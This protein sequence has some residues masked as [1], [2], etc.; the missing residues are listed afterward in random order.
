MGYKMKGPSLYKHLTTKPRLSEGLHVNHDA[1]TNVSDGRAGSSAFQMQ[2]DLDKDGKM[3]GYE[4]A[5]QTAIEKN[6]KKGPAKMYGKKS[7]TKMKDG[8][9]TKEDLLKEGFTPADADKMMKDGATTG[10]PKAKAKKKDK[11]KIDNYLAKKEGFSNKLKD[12]F[13]DLKK[14]KKDESCGDDKDI[15]KKL[16]AA[17][18]AFK[19]QGNK[20]TD[21]KVE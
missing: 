5:R 14:V 2:G 1:K 3:S 15:K 7:P 18:K 13:S 8:K 9:K 17:K 20:E 12:D 21:C 19:L 4:T 10:R 11:F 16:F 6:M